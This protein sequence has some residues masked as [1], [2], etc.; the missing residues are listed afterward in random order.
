MSL[1]ESIIACAPVIQQLQREASAVVVADTRQ[2]VAVLPHPQIPIP[3]KPGDPLEQYKGT[4]I[5]RVITT[6]QPVFTRVSKKVLGFPYFS[7]TQPLYENGQLVGAISLLTLTE[8]EDRLQAQAHELSALVDQLSAN[9]ESLSQSA[10]EVASANDDMSQHAALAQERIQLT[11]TV[12]SFIHEVAAQS[13]L[14]G[15]N[16]AIEAARAGE[17]GRGF[18]VVADEIRRLAQRSQSASKEIEDSLSQIRTAV[19]RM[20]SDIQTSSKYTEAQASAAEE[21]AASLGQISRAAETLARL[22]RADAGGEH[23]P[24]AAKDAVGAV[25][26]QTADP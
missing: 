14:L 11:S 24:G 5:Y 25:T 22:S 21:L 17:S 12:L 19:E 10:S 2:F 8:R 4:A 9:A 6:G 1:L 18:A 15:L 3:G 20:V 13:N 23:G 26:G 16:A 7:A